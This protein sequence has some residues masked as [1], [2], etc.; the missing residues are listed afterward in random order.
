MPLQSPKEERDEV[1]A[2]GGKTGKDSWSGDD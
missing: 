2:S 1:T